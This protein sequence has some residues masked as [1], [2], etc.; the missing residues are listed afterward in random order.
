MNNKGQ[1]S[2]IAALLVA[3][4][5]IASAMG[6]YSAIRFS[7]IQ[8]QPQ[9]L[10]SI[11]ETN[12][13]LKQLLGFTVGYYGSVLKVTGNVTY[14]QK[15]AQ[16]YLDSGIVNMG[17]I[18]PEWGLSLNTTQVELKANWFTNDSYSQGSMNVTY[19]L[20]GLGITGVSYSASS[21]LEVQVSNINSTTQ[22][23]FKILTDNGEPLINLAADNLKFFRYVFGNL[24]WEFSVPTNVISHADGTYIVDLPSGVPSNAY[25]VQVE[26]TRGLSVLAASYSQFTSAIAWNKTAYKTELGLCR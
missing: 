2:I 4:V 21:R 9:I 23:Q 19:D 16:N 18:K 10:S 13:A 11:D 6:T 26:D 22:A 24:T 15:L 12:Q 3:V 5:L 14:A 1:F 20:N 7:P 25:V 17:S 8:E